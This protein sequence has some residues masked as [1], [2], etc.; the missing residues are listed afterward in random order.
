MVNTGGYSLYSFLQSVKQFGITAFGPQRGLPSGIPAAATASSVKG[1][2]LGAPGYTA[3]YAAGA[4]NAATVAAWQAAYPGMT[5]NQ[6]N[7]LITFMGLGGGIV[8]PQ[9]YAN[10]QSLQQDPAQ[11]RPY[12]GDRD[13]NKMRASLNWQANEKLT[14]TGSV[15]YNRDDYTNSSI[16]L[17]D[18]SNFAL[19]LEGAF[20]FNEKVST[21]LYYTYGYQRQDMSFNNF[22]T[23]APTGTATGTI[24]SNAAGSII[25]GCYDNL[26]ARAQN[27]KVDPCNKWGTTIRDTNDTIGLN[28]STK[29]LLTHKLDLAGD[30]LYSWANTSQDFSGLIA[31]NSLFTTTNFGAGGATTWTTAYIPMQALPDVKSEV[32]TFKLNGKY[33]VD[34]HSAARF[35]YMY[36]HL[37]SSN[38][39]YQAL[40]AGSTATGI[41]PTNEKAPNYSLHTIGAAYVYNF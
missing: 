31:V 36:Q 8:A 35:G 38:W 1:G 30:I 39:F 37:T 9:Y 3:G 34:K 21:S 28:M 16:G 4:D 17:Q 18:S 33:T 6:A 10:G 23:N 19:N 25:G 12:V 22:G 26:D 11:Q 7:A 15:D 5:V 29:G 24:A 41:M 13:R 32:F 20:A 2:T 14:L 27:A 40:Q